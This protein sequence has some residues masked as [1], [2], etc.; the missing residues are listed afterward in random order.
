MR[1]TLLVNAT[2][3]ALSLITSAEGSNRA[4]TTSGIFATI[5]GGANLN[6]QVIGLDVYNE[7]KQ[8][9]GEIVDVA[10]S[11]DGQTEACILS[12]G[13]ILGMGER[14]VAIRRR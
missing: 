7:S 10:M 13:G 14:Y 11:Q 3:L 8:D 12:V 2:V 4:A 9:V 1:A 5:S 6:S